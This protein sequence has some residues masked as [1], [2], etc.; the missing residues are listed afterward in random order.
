MAIS[1][2]FQAS[3]GQWKKKRFFDLAS[4]WS[5][6]AI[7]DS[8]LKY[9]NCAYSVPGLSMILGTNYFG[10]LETYFDLFYFLDMR[11]RLILTEVY[12]MSKPWLTKINMRHFIISVMSVLIRVPQTLT[13]RLICSVILKST[14]CRWSD[15]DLSEIIQ[16]K[17][18]IKTLIR[19]HGKLSEFK[20]V[21]VAQTRFARDNYSRVQPTFAGQSQTF[22]VGLKWRPAG[23]GLP[24]HVCPWEHS[25]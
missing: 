22:I 5:A 10:S 1:P 7:P 19:N 6:G 14:V 4:N 17:N 18:N 25:L 21:W 13:A 24:N 15:F 3:G 8:C 12:D 9:N 11:Y 23:Q 20:C 2:S 16:W